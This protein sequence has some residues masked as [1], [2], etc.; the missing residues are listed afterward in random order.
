MA[1]V[2]GASKAE[3]IKHIYAQFERISL[4]CVLILLGVIIAWATVFATIK[5]ISD[6]AF[7]E[8]FMDKAALQDTFGL[9][10]AVVIL[11]EFNHSIFVALTNQT[12]AVQTRIVVLITILVIVRKLVLQDIA[13]LDFQTLVGW[14]VL[15]VSLGGLYWLLSGHSTS[16]GS[17][18]AMEPPA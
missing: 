15:L 9:I 10:F 5:L 13:A 16:L 11:L 4:A 7:S 8:S 18:R 6:L 12:G 1:V 2:S 3:W 17:P 14:G